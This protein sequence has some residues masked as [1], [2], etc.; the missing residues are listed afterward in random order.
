MS[1][2]QYEQ[3]VVIIQGLNVDYFDV[4]TTWNLNIN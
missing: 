4:Y 3:L 2:S 1:P